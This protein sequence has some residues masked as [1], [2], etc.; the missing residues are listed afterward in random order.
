M[1]SY[2]I[3]IQHHSIS[4]NNINKYKHCFEM[5]WMP[6]CFRVEVHQPV[7]WSIRKLQLL[8]GTRVKLSPLIEPASPAAILGVFTF[9]IQCSNE[10]FVVPCSRRHMYTTYWTQSHWKIF[11]HIWTG[12]YCK[13]LN[14]QTIPYN[15]KYINTSQHIEPNQHSQ[16]M[17]NRSQWIKKYQK[18]ISKPFETFQNH[19]A[20]NLQPFCSGGMLGPSTF[21][22]PQPQ[23]P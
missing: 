19:F 14:K 1:Y 8:L 4:L 7:W 13:R 18:Y 20:R 15:S 10:T 16:T 9:C 3:I 12:F 2:V 6:A 22:L 17:S 5:L 11:E 23:P 21:W